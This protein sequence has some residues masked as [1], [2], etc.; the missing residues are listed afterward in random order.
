MNRINLKKLLILN[1]P[2]ILVGLFATNF[3]EAWR[4]AEG[5]DSSAKILSFFYALPVALGN[6]LPSLHPLDLLV[7]IACGAGLRLA[8]YLKAKKP[9][10]TG[11]MWSMV[12]PVGVQPKTLSRSPLQSLRT[13]LS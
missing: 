1:I 12:L 5:A 2:Y 9:R 13:I 10:S 8:V 7:G 3:G 6:P 11:T 4:L